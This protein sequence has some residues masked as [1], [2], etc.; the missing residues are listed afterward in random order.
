MLWAAASP[1]QPRPA[2]RVVASESR[3]YW[4]GEGEYLVQRGQKSC[5]CNLCDEIQWGL[6][7]WDIAVVRHSHLKG[8]RKG[9][10]RGSKRQARTTA[11]VTYIQYYVFR[12]VPR[13]QPI[14]DSSIRLIAHI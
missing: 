9:A 10:S 6:T 8:V 3:I 12:T 2:T 5:G 1:S 4:R 13:A 7:P 11:R 14:I